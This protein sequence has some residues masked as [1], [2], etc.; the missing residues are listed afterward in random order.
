MPRRSNGPLKD[1]RFCINT[2]PLQ[3]EVHDL[4]NECH[5]CCIDEIVSMGNA[6]PCSNVAVAVISGYPRCKFCINKG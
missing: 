3:P 5:R 2:N 4:E 6:E 1:A